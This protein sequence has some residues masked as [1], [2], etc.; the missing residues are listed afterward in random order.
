MKYENQ[1]PG[2]TPEFD[3]RAN[4]ARYFP[5]KEHDLVEALRVQYLK[6]RVERARQMATCPKCSGTFE[7]HPFKG[8]VLQRCESCEGI[9]LNKGDLA[10]MLRQ[11]A[12]G[13]L[14]ILI[15][16]CFSRG[17]KPVGS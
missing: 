9:W 5:A 16:R 2:K 3:G 4:E 1:R 11:Q 7:K 17:D 14:G 15:G 6:K 12:R 8:F 13:P 10:K